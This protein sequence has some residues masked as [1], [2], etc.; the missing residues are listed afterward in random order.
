VAAAEG[1]PHPRAPRTPLGEIDMV[2]RRGR[3][4]AFVEV[5]ARGDLATAG[6]ALT[7]VGRRRISRA[8]NLLLARYGQDVE[9]ARVDAILVTPWRLP[10]HVPGAW[11]GE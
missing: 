5:K 2:A 7:D 6:E 1:L 10:Q 4:L 8:S 3:T 9:A 11:L